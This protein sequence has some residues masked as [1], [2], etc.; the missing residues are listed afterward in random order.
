MM[1][2]AKPIIFVAVASV[3]IPQLSHMLRISSLE[4]KQISSSQQNITSI[5]WIRIGI[6]NNTSRSFSN[7]EQLFQTSDDQSAPSI[8][9][10]LVPSTGAVVTVK[11][12]VNLRKDRPQTDYS[13]MPK[14][15]GKLKPGEKVVILKLDALVNPDANSHRK[16]VWGQVGR[17][18]QACGT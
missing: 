15:V 4:P 6:V 9:A 11:N 17:C 18:N 8:D 7:E 13:H 3:F 12:L 14:T 1:P 5:G 2:F 10:P 16:E